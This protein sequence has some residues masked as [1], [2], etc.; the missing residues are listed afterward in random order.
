MLQ[1]KLPTTVKSQVLRHMI[2]AHLVEEYDFYYPKI[3][4][5]LKSNSLSFSA[6]VINVYNGNIWVDEYILDALGEMFN[7]KVSVVSPA[8]DDVWDIFHRSA[9]PNIV[10]ISNGGDF[11]RKHGATHF[12]ATKGMEREWRCVGAD[13]E[14]GE[15]GLRTGYQAGLDRTVEHFYVKEKQKLLKQVRKTSGNVEELC[16]DLSNLC[17]RRDKIYDEVQKL[18]IK[19]ESFKQLGKFYYDPPQSTEETVHRTS[20]KRKESKHHKSQKSKTAPR[21]CGK[22]SQEVSTN[23]L[24]ETLSEMDKGLDMEKLPDQSAE[25]LKSRP[26]G[27]RVKN[28]RPPKFPSLPENTDVI[29]LEHEES[30]TVTTVKELK[31]W[32]VSTETQRPYNLD[33]SETVTT[34]EPGVIEERAISPEARVIT[35]Q[36]QSA[37]DD[38]F[39]TKRPAEEQIESDS[40]KRRVNDNSDR[41]M[42]GGY[43]MKTAMIRAI[44]QQEI[45]EETQAKEDEQIRTESVQA[46]VH[47]SCRTT[48]MLTEHAYSDI[49]QNTFTDVTPPVPELDQSKISVGGKVDVDTTLWEDAKFDDQDNIVGFESQPSLNVF[50]P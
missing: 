32:K 3:Q 35:E 4:N 33:V 1:L 47:R 8:Y 16:H 20:A 46:E 26:R 39:P 30:Q 2:A 12:S 13:D 28:A 22:F 44:E 21:S 31:Q 48:R 17:I 18:G 38:I 45:R 10:L 7:I 6:Y 19:V 11:G 40:K 37:Q 25:I 49:V 34:T 15:M 24:S 36:P 23:I 14:I 27:C 50:I 9:F 29:D 43:P 41:V 5:Y 42:Y